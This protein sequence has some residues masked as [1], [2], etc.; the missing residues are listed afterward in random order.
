MDRAPGDDRISPGTELD[1][2]DA[3]GR[4]LERVVVV[5]MDGDRI[6][7]S[8]SG[9]PARHG[10]LVLVELPVPGDARYEAPARVEL[11]PPDR[12]A[13][14]RAGGWDRDQRRAWV[15]IN[16]Y[17]VDVSVAWLECESAEPPPEPPKDDSPSY[18][19]LNI[20]AGGL[21]L[22]ADDSLSVGDAAMCH[23]E[24]PGEASFDLEARVVRVES[25]GLRGRRRRVAFEFVG[26]DDARRSALL[27][28]IYREQVR[29]RLRLK[30]LGDAP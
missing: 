23:F 26:I 24:L 1:V 21:S 12:Y 10:D 20:S 22:V 25:G 7:L 27:R 8:G 28:W 9:F 19:M 15:R 4:L 2:K 13:L 17:G 11:H 6:W 14:R 3:N 5:R 29:R 18:P 30:S 16:T